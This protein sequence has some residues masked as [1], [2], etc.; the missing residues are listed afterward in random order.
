MS[1]G[2]FFFFLIFILYTLTLLP[3]K[4]MA[5]VNASSLFLPPSSFLTDCFVM[6][7]L[8]LCC[9]KCEPSLHLHLFQVIQLLKASVKLCSQSLPLCDDKFY[10]FSVHSGCFHMAVV[11]TS[12]YLLCV[13]IVSSCV[14]LHFTFQTV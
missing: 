11:A 13:L 5:L 7:L 8:D 4:I 6:W 2:E 14:V 9:I 1:P 10:F 12:N 3:S